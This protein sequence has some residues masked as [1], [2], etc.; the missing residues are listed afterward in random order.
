MC[1]ANTPHTLRMM[2]QDTCIYNYEEADITI[3]RYLYMFIQEGKM[4]IQVLADDTDIF[5][6]L[7][8]YC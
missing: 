1:E 5:I 8:Y 3:I 6:L 7:V 4:S 2:G